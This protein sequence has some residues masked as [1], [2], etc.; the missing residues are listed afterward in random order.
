MT[1]LAIQLTADDAV[2]GVIAVVLGLVAVLAGSPVV[3]WLF[4][5]VDR[6]EHTHGH[7][8]TSQEQ[9]GPQAHPQASAGREPGRRDQ[10]DE[11]L[12]P[13]YRDSVV[14]AASTL[15]GGHWIGLLERLTVYVAILAGFPEGIAMAL[16]VKSLARYPEL[17][18][19]KTSATAERFIIGTFASVLW[20]LACA[21][22]TVWLRSLFPR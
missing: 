17:Q 1:S 16:A 12:A 6:D 3:R 19:G 10:P 18:A 21:G 2:H 20:A 9:A 5:R 13:P 15:R 22:L 4:R 14:A 11:E 7:A 8:E